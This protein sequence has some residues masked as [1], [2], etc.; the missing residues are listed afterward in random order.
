ME[1]NTLVNSDIKTYIPNIRKNSINSVVT[2]PPYY[3]M[4]DYEV[5]GQLGL[6]NT[7]EDYLTTLC[8]VFFSLEDCLADDGIICVNIGD[9]KDK[10]I[11]ELFKE[12]MRGKYRVLQEFL[13]SKIGFGG[14]RYDE[15]IQIYGK[16]KSKSRKHYY[17]LIWFINPHHS[18]EHPATMP[19]ELAERMILMSSDEN[20]LVLDPFMGS[21][22]TAIACIQNNRNWLGVDINHKYTTI[23][24]NR[25]Q[26]E[27]LKTKKEKL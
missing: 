19:V 11:P 5:G 4:R 7:L 14:K 8:D 15:K 18:K 9:T 16:E 12:R 6:E 21:G 23:A 10:N 3:R 25:I 1:I 2:S 24:N 20:D 27:L 22:T 17:D 26:K 13:W